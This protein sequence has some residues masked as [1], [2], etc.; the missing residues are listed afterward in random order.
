MNKVLLAGNIVRAPELRYTSN[1]TAVCN[2]TIATNEYSKDK[3]TGER[4]QFTEYTR[5]ELWGK[6]AENFAKFADKG[7]H[8]VIDGKLKTRKWT[9]DAGEDRYS[10]VVQVREF[11]FTGKGKGADAAS[12]D[13]PADAPADAPI[14]DDDIPF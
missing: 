2:A 11:E 3:Q 6:Q 13:A 1:K 5:L 8:V 14:N 4:K 10:T 9:T 7:R 12:T